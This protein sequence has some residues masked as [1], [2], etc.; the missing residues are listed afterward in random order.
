MDRNIQQ[1][2][3]EAELPDI[4]RKFE[5]LLPVEPLQKSLQKLEKLG[6]LEIKDERVKLTFRG[7][8]VYL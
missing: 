7:R 8:Y 1:A 5:T 2:N 6:Y 3:Q 4:Y